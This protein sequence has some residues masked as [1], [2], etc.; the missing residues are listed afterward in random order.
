MQTSNPPRRIGILG[1]EGVMALDMTAP[2]E[3]FTTAN[4]LSGEGAPLY[5]VVIVGLE[6]GPFRSE[7]GLRMAADVSLEEAGTLDTIIV[8]GGRGLRVGSVERAAAWLKARAPGTRRVA[9]VCTGLY[10]LAATGLLDG[11]KVTTHWRFAADIAR[12]FPALRM[13]ADALYVKEGRFYTAAGVTAGVDL[14]LALVEEDHGPRLALAVAREL[15][16]YFKRPGGQL[17]YSEPLQFQVRA[18]DRF[19]DLAAWLPDHLTQDLSVEALARRANLSP[20][21]FTRR[22]KAA[23]GASPADYV[24]ALR[25]DTARQ[26]L[27]AAGQTIDS[28]AASAGFNSADVFRRAFERRFGVAPSAYRNGFGLQARSSAIAQAKAATRA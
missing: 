20:R 21:H 24:E 7:S 10:A 14:A 11:L 3:V 1:Y 2:L 16:V 9:S 8:P 18:T 13:S 15:V 12:R 23:F 6:P 27:G 28:V 25:L 19:A 22:F 26:R 4:D 5:D 17:Q